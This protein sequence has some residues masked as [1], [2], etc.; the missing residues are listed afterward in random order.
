MRRDNRW[1]SVPYEDKVSEIVKSSTYLN[2]VS[3]QACPCGEVLRLA[4][5]WWRECMGCGQLI[6]HGAVGVGTWDDSDGMQYCFHGKGWRDYQHGCG[7]WNSPTEVSAE[8]L[9]DETWEELLRESMQRLDALVAEQYEDAVHAIRQDLMSQVSSVQ[10]CGHAEDDE[11]YECSFHP[12]ETG[13]EEHPG[14]YIDGDVIVAWKFDP[15]FEGELIEVIEV[16][17]VRKVDN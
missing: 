6:S 17:T 14:V 2:A 5:R 7:T 15:L 4:T 11:L 3:S 13:S 16:R 9:D 10:D 12:H 8:W 1:N